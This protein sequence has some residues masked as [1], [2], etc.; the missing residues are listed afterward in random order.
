MGAMTIRLPD[1]LHDEIRRLAEEEKRS[2]SNEIVWLL[3]Q[4]LARRGN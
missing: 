4:T 1:E 2:V 3:A